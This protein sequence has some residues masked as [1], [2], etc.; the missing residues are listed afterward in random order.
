M[1]G[2][3]WSPYMFGLGRGP[4]RPWKSWDGRMDIVGLV[5]LLFVRRSGARWYNSTYLRLR[6]S[7]PSKVLRS[8]V[9]SR[10]TFPSPLFRPLHVAVVICCGFVL[11]PSHKSVADKPVHARYLWPQVSQAYSGRTEIIPC[12]F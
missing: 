7:G 5:T 1:K 4:R 12:M 9:I 3:V 6:A 2:L 11:I 10:C 8:L